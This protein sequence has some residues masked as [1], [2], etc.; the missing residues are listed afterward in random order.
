MRAA[1]VFKVF[2]SWKVGWSSKAAR[3]GVCGHGEEPHSA[4]GGATLN[5][6]PKN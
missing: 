4:S 3:F 5:P 2:R 1:W 6:K